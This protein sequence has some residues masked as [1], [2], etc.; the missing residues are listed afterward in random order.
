MGHG[1]SGMCVHPSL[2]NA[3]HL[4]LQRRGLKV[5]EDT[6]R[7]VRGGIEHISVAQHLGKE[8]E[9]RGQNVAAPGWADRN[10]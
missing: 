7:C 9:D 6:P 2:I 10:L 8:K 5:I 4:N 1:T 3:P